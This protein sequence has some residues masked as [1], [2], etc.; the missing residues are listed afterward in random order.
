MAETIL[1]TIDLPLPLSQILVPEDQRESS[2][3]F[4]LARKTEV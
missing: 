3:G 1:G 4:L 2:G